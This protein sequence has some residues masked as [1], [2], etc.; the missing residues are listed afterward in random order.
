MYVITNIVYLSMTNLLFPFFKFKLTI[1]ARVI[2][3]LTNIESVYFLHFSIT[4]FFLVFKNKEILR[5]FCKTSFFVVIFRNGKT[6]NYVN[7]LSIIDIVNVGFP[8]LL[9][10]LVYQNCH[11]SCRS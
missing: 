1:G 3:F 9:L 2:F 7:L 8:Y 10:L 5:R 4:T 11:Q 6:E